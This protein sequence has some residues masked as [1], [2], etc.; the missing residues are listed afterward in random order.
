MP[1]PGSIT[2]VELLGRPR[3]A[4]SLQEEDRVILNAKLS[5]LFAALIGLSLLV[6][7][8]DAAPSK[9]AANAPKNVLKMP[10][11]KGGA[12]PPKPAAA[13][14]TPVEVK[15]IPQF[16]P[17][18]PP[19]LDEGQMRP[20]LAAVIKAAAFSVSEEDGARWIDGGPCWVWV[21]AK[22]ELDWA[23]YRFAYEG[24]CKQG[25]AD[26][27]GRLKAEG[28]DGEGKWTPLYEIDG[29]F[30]SGIAQSESKESANVRFAVGLRDRTVLTYVGASLNE[31]GDVFA[32]ALADDQGRSS[33]CASQALLAVA[34]E[35]SADDASL[36][37]L[38]RRSVA[39]MA[40]ECPDRV[41]QVWRTTLV[42][43]N[44]L[45]LASLD[46][47]STVAPI[48]AQAEIREGTIFDYASGPEARPHLLS[49][50]KPVFGAQPLVWTETSDDD[51]MTLALV[52]GIPLLL[53]LLLQITAR[54][55]ARKD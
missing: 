36:R 30:L 43:K 18:G 1:G 52:V 28:L 45:V 2:L 41:A 51:D 23:K 46:G 12:T 53:I 25:R 16:V 29:A 9:S 8:A 3:P 42:S 26:G 6:G 11:S 54:I 55:T 48:L 10:Q 17:P 24:G 44:G 22:H 50:A 13:P 47:A 14:R 15:E 20:A 21:A 37:Q 38:L 4:C 39:V 32:A 40:D 31:E 35:E 5:S 27:K 33:I 19:P 34:N 49:Q 7:G